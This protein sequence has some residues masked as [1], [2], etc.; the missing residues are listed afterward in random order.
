MQPLY[1]TAR[2]FHE[3][4]QIMVFTGANMFLF[5]TVVFKELIEWSCSW[6]LFQGSNDEEMW[7]DLRTHT[8]D[9][10]LSYAGQF[11]S[12]PIHVVHMLICLSDYSESFLQDLHQAPHNHGTFVYVSYMATSIMRSLLWN[13]PR[14]MG[15]FYLFYSLCMTSLM[16]YLQLQKFTC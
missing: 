11:V 4:Y 5:E 6:W 9:R 2:R 13:D 8:D 3:L 10:T 12:W 15:S 1:Y 14:V 7:I 16:G